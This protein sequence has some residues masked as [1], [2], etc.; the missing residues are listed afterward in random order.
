M[1]SSTN[2]LLFF[3]FSPILYRTFYLLTPPSELPVLPSSLA[4]KDEHGEITR[5][6]SYIPIHIYTLL[7]IAITVGIFIITLT[8]AAPAFPVLIIAL[9]PFRLLIMKHWFWREVLRFVDA[10]ACREG[11]PEDDEDAKESLNQGHAESDSGERGRCRDSGIL[12]PGS[13]DGSSDPCQPVPQPVPKTMTV[14]HD[15]FT[16]REDSM[17][18]WVELDVRMHMDEELGRDLGSRM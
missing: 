3:P 9:V 10:W 4:R 15:T 1:I 18:E 12:S 7:Q 14:N 16:M 8:R 11:T 2:S 6:P 13:V 5:K 17:H